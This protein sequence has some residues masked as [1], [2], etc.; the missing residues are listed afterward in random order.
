MS[1]TW[2]T[3]FALRTASNGVR[4]TVDISLPSLSSTRNFQSKR[5][6]PYSSELKQG[7]PFSS[8]MIIL[9]Y[10]FVLSASTCA[11]YFPVPVVTRLAGFRSEICWF[12]PSTVN[13]PIEGC[14]S[15]SQFLGSAAQS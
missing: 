8:P 11:D 3:A 1:P 12:I 5:G 7:Y 2:E 13:V 9:L 15:H 6:V 4:D 14:T 10:R